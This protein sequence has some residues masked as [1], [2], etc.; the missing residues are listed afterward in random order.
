MLI[1]LLDLSSVSNASRREVGIDTV[2]YL[3]DTLGRIELPN[4]SDLIKHLIQA[5]EDVLR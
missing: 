5:S 3:L 4:S 1:A 2:A